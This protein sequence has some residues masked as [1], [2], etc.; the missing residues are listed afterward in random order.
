MEPLTIGGAL[1]GTNLNKLLPELAILIMLVVLLSATAYIT[2]KKAHKMYLKEMLGFS[3]VQTDDDERDVE[4]QDNV[5]LSPAAS[6]NKADPVLKSQPSDDKSTGEKKDEIIDNGPKLVQND[7]LPKESKQSPEDESKQDATTNDHVEDTSD[8]F[9]DEHALHFSAHV[10]GNEE[11]CVHKQ[12]TH[13]RTC[14]LENVLEEEQR[15]PP[16]NVITILI[17][18]LLVLAM[19]IMKGGGGFESP[20]GIECGSLSFWGVEVSIFVF[21]LVVCWTSRSHLIQRTHLKQAMGYKY[22][23]GDIRW[24]ER[25]TITYPLVCCLAGLVAG[26]FGVGGG[27]VKGPLMLALGVHPMVASAT[28][29]CMILFTSF[30][31][32]TSFM[33]FGLLVTDYAVACLVL[34]FVA[35]IVGQTVMSLLLRRYKRNSYIAFSIGI[36]VAI[37]AI[38][39]STESIISLRGQGMSRGSGSLCNLHSHLEI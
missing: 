35:T 31:A 5:E 21:I 8:H 27:I 6:N 23:E 29:A 1:I 22:V 32:T 11:I 25:S 37:S 24:D 7:S 17:M 19:N 33:I 30:T 12:G 3:K 13:L 2:L 36:V 38:C 39:M 34:G 15:A 18:F 9:E 4:A 10:M 28:S 16:R 26:M 20:V 14:T